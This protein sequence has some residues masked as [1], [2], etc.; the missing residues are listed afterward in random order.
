MELEMTRRR[1]IAEVMAERKTVHEEIAM[2]QADLDD[3]ED[4]RKKLDR[5]LFAMLREDGVSEFRSDAGLVRLHERQTATTS[6]WDAFAVWL[7]Q[8]GLPPHAV[9]NKALSAKALHEMATS[10]IPLPECVTLGTT[11]Q[12]RFTPKRG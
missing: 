12:L 11:E 1:K 7:N 3:L 4:R 6:D 5:E 9:M 8:Q 2:V 10:G